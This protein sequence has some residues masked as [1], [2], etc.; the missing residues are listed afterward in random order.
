[1]D[2][3]D[4]LFALAAGYAVVTGILYIIRKQFSYKQRNPPQEIRYT[5]RP[6]VYLGT[7]HLTGGLFLAA[8]LVP[9]FYLLMFVGIVIIIGAYIIIT[10]RY[11]G[12][13]IEEPSSK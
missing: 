7:A 13:I 1:M 11:E 12:E 6:A 9:E 2:I 8:S 10:R 3:I 4:T 5:G